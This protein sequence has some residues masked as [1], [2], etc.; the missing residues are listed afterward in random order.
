VRRLDE[1]E[2]LGRPLLVG[3]SRKSTLGA[4]TGAN[5]GTAAASVGA[6]VAAY[7]AARRSS[8]PMMCASTSRRW[9]RRGRC[10]DEGR[11]ARPARLRLP[12]RRGGGAA[13]RQLFLFDIE[14]EVGDRGSSDRIEE[15]VDYREVALAVREMSKQ[16]FNLLEALA[17][18]VADELYA[19]FSPEWVRVRVRK[20]QVKPA[21]MAVEYSAVTVERP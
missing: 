15:A 10:R 8:A 4:L 13:A 20:P 21:G 17:P 9:P 16:R 11:A 7:A 3:F 1:L 14:L 19:R 6:A 5:V 18:A 12:R 2:T